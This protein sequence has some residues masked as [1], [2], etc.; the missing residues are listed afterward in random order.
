MYKVGVILTNKKTLEKYKQMSNN[1]F[2]TNLNV[3]PI[4]Q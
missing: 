1:K 4:S 2:I 3:S